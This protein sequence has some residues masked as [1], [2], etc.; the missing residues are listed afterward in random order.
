MRDFIITAAIVL[1]C[2]QATTA[3]AAQSNPQSIRALIALGL[4]TNLGLQI[5]RVEVEKGTEAIQI[6]TAVFDSTLFAVA[7]YDRSSTPYESSF[8]SSSQMNSEKLS[9]QVGVGKRFQGGLTTSLSLDS[10]WVSDNDSSHSLDPRYRTALFLDLN[11]PLLRNLGSSINTTRL[12]ISRNQQRQV[13]LEYLLQAQHLTLQLEAVARRL[14]AKAEIVQ[15]RQRALDLA[16]D[17]YSA[18]K[19]RFSA[20][21]I[22]V[23]EV[24]EAET[25]LEARHLN[26]SLAIQDRDLLLE[27]LNRHL[28][29]SLSKEFEPEVLVDYKPKIEL[30]KFPAFNQLF[31]LAQHKRLELKI[32]GYAVKSSSLQQDYLHNQLKPQLD[33]NFQ[34]GVNGLSGEERKPTFTSQYSGDWYDSF[35]SMSE[36]DGYQWRAGL[37]F[38]MPLGNRSAKSRYRQSEL[39]LKQDHYRQQD[40]QAVIEN[41]LLQQQVNIFHAK[42]QLRITKRF[43]SLAE[44]TLQ[45]E[46][47]RLEEGLSDT[48]RMIIFQQKMI[49][50]KIDRINAITRY[51][52][53]IAQMQFATGQVFERHNIILTINTEELDLEKI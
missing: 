33:L 46:Q 2:I 30:I 14:A 18:N 17:L 39:Q 20:G 9:A 23:T 4:K 34:V 50:A 29:H 3:L 5:D 12:Q 40:L 41:D 52:L 32:N 15:L 48:F 27:D 53:A 25:A 35:G 24:Q 36:A 16:D 22:P 21:V 26:L 31:E 19:K 43:E 51:H 8:S 37:E 7:G 11:Q 44:T 28:N 38:S 1:C 6:E 42:E 10:N 45:Q 47:R 13:S 49:E